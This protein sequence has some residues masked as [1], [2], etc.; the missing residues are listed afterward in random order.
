MPQFTQGAPNIKFNK[1]DVSKLAPDETAI[2]VLFKDFQF[3]RSFIGK[4]PSKIFLVVDLL[5]HQSMATAAVDIN[6]GAFD[7]R[8]T[9]VC[10]N[11]FFLSE[12][13]ERTSA[14]VQ[15]CRQRESQVTE[16]SRTELNM[17]P[18][19]RGYTSMTQ[20]VALWNK[21]NKVVGKVTFE[22][23]I[24]RAPVGSKSEE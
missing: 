11:D 24:Y 16:A 15:L 7:A 6:S 5:E 3:E 8:L 19:V 12:F 22:A 18:F 17:L 2:A 20:T 13:L 10:T 14:G 21:A 4:K 1:S 9:F 23:A